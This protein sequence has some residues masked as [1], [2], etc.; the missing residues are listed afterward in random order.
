MVPLL[1]TT[2][3]SPQSIS[4]LSEFSALNPDIDSPGELRKGKLTTEKDTGQKHKRKKH[5][6]SKRGSRV[7]PDWKIEAL[8]ALRILAEV[9]LANKNVY[10]QCPY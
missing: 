1:D 4:D 7:A 9:R 10:S 6:N 5:Q 2:S 8:T 3:R